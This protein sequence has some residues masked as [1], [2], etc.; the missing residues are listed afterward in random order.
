V[1]RWPLKS[2]AKVFQNFV[3]FTRRS[4]FHGRNGF[5]RRTKSVDKIGITKI[6][7]YNN[8]M[9]SSI[10]KMFRCCSKIFGCSNKNF[11]GVPNFVAVT[12]PF[13]PCWWNRCGVLLRKL[14][15]INLVSPER[16]LNCA[17]T[18]KHSPENYHEA[19]LLWRWKAGWISRTFFVL[20]TV[21]N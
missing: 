15:R 2:L 3:P 19:E 18:K 11:F 9:F 14:W 7:C 8:K 21:K 5:V 16:V 1:L 13:F 12:K 4:V 17:L 10:N 20:N 6:F